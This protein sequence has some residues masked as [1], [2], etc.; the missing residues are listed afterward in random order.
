MT[1]SKLG[2]VARARTKEL[3]TRIRA[4]MTEIEAEIELNDGIYPRNKGRLTQAEVCR[5]AGTSPAVLQSP[6]HKSTTL[7]EVKAWLAGI[8]HKI[9]IGHKKIRRTVTDR[10]DMWE[11]MYL[12]A[13]H[14]SNL[15]HLQLA[16]TISRLASA[17]EQ[18]K[19]LEAEVVRLQAKLSGGAVVKMDAKRKR[20][21]D[22]KAGGNR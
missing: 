15:Y 11:Q 1:D 5:R 2:E 18:V 20:E 8:Q 12:A 7:R 3:V 14:H 9:A 10:S 22:T 4:A 21:A 16:T 6:T 17:E 19:E 13:A